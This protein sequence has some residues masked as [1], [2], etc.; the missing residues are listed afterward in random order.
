MNNIAITGIEG[1]IGKHLLKHLACRNDMLI[2]GLT[3]KK[4]PGNMPNENNIEF[5]NGDLLDKESLNQFPP[6]DGIVVNLAYIE[7]MTEK[8]NIQAIDNLAKTCVEAKIKRLIHCSTAVVAGR[9]LNVEI[10]E[11]VVCRPIS[12]YEITK[13]AIEKLLME[14]YSKSYEII[15]LRPTAVFGPEGKNLIK[16]A[17]NLMDGNQVINYLRSCLLNDRKMNLVAVENVVASID[18]LI[19]YKKKTTAADI[20]I[21]SDDDDESNTYRGVEVLL[22]SYLEK[23]DY[24]LPIIRIPLFVL[25]TLLLILGRTNCNPLTIHNSQKLIDEGFQKRIPLAKS[26]KLFAEWY[27]QKKRTVTGQVSKLRQ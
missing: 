15:I 18:F 10:D 4:N 17:D 8:E 14:K 16:M 11:N 9:T 19:H 21:I 2:R 3:Y 25:S 6:K 22:M 27:N 5:F 13:L 7:S 23:K 26:L 1:F 24:P 12:R 20:F